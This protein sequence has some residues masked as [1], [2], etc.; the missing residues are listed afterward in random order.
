MKMMN[1]SLRLVLSILVIGWLFNSLTSSY[2]VGQ[3]PPLSPEAAAAMETALKALSDSQWN[4][5]EASFAHVLMRSQRYAPAYIG[6]MCAELRVTEEKLL[7]D[8]TVP[9]D[10]HRYFK[11]ALQLA[12]D[13]Y[14]IQIQGY[15]DTIKENIRKK[16]IERDVPDKSN[17]KPGDSQEL[18][19]N[20]IK[21]TFRW[22]PSGTFVMGKGA[23]PPSVGAAER[24]SSNFQGKPV[25]LTRGFWLLETEVTQEMW[26]S[27]MEDNPS[28]FKGAKLPVEQV[29]WDDCQ[30]YIKKLNELKVAPAGF[31]FSLPT[32]A[33]WEYAC[34]AGTTTEYHFGL[35]VGQLGSYAWH[36]ENSD[37][38]T[39]E[40]GQK[41]ANEWGLYDMYG[42]VWEWC[43]DIWGASAYFNDAAVTNPVGEPRGGTSR[44]IRGGAWDNNAEQCRSA[45]RR[46]SHPRMRFAYIGFRLALVSE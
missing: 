42:N 20:G 24:V 14:K 9:I 35:Y 17:N 32:E 44:V 18:T 45:F 38:Q 25:T 3:T 46:S 1:S 7:G 11:T 40:V 39:H 36:R 26:D 15:A 6:R 23:N 37:V 29:F 16:E 27:V 21:Y 12:D 13:E 2:I 41:K 43:Q 19:I 10:E 33:Q 28:R 8:L 4:Q 31:K 5:A 30:E 22:C 34:R